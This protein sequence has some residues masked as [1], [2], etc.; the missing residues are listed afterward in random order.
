MMDIPVSMNYI[1]FDSSMCLNFPLGQ[2]GTR[3]SYAKMA[4]RF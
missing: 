1:T 4:L 2:A 3:Y